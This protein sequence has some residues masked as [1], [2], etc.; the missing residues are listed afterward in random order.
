MPDTI[1]DR[2]MCVSLRICSSRSFVKWRMDHIDSCLVLTVLCD[3]VLL[4][5]P[6]RLP[7]KRQGA[8]LC[9][10]RSA[11][12]E[13]LP[14]PDETSSSSR[15]LCRISSYVASYAYLLV[16]CS[17]NRRL[18]RRRSGSSSS[19]SS[20]SSSSRPYVSACLSVYPSIN[21]RNR[22]TDDLSS[23]W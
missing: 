15:S 12:C 13:C 14:S 23:S 17:Y 8:H 5:L 3:G 21:R 16:S 7:I 1:R 10:Q 20:R 2:F 11:T 18:P 4:D 6:I 22:R 19:T 9:V